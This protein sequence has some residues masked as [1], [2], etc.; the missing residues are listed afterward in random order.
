MQLIT[1]QIPIN[2]MLDLNKCD[3]YRD[4]YS[5]QCDSF[6]QSYFQETNL[7]LYC[8][9]KSS[10]DKDVCIPLIKP[11]ARFEKCNFYISNCAIV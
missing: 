2:I 3:S 6:F 8:L 1:K 11:I 10:C 5:N 7:M 4:I 9:K